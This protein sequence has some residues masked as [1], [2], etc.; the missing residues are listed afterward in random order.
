MCLDQECHIVQVSVECAVQ[1]CGP[2]LI[3]MNPHSDVQKY[4]DTH[5]VYVPVRQ[6]VDSLLWIA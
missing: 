1:D 5:R 2:S 6:L 3:I 4:D